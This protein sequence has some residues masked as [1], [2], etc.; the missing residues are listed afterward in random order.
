MGEEMKMICTICARGGSKGVKGKN[1]R[2]L[3]GKPLISYS[4]EQA[5]A[6]GLFDTIAVSSDSQEILNVAHTYGA[7]IMIIRPDE[8][9][10]DTAGKVPAIRHCVLEVEKMTGIKY[11]IVVDIDAT[12]PLRDVDDIKNAVAM[13]ENNLVSNVITAVSARKSPYFNMVELDDCG[14]AHLSKKLPVAVVRRQDAPR[15]YDMNASIYVWR[16]DVFVSNPAVFYDDTRL[17]VMREDQAVDIDTELDFLIVERIMTDKE[18]R[19]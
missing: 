3:L 15:C 14:Y 16:R 17:Y 10:S 2:P 11:D 13:L 6:S 1:I 12:A 18:K 19:S 7:D 9:A 5:R 4:I 8:L